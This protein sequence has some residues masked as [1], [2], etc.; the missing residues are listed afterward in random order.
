MVVSQWQQTDSDGN[1]MSLHVSTPEDG[2]IFP[3]VVVIQHQSG[4]DGFIQ[5]MTERLAGAGYVAVAPD[6]YHRD[7]PNC[8]DDMR[9]R[10]ARLG[11]RRVIVDVSAT[12]EFLKR[13]RAV[14]P[15]RIGIVGFCMGGRIVYLMAAAIPAF[16]AAVT[17]YPGNT[18]RAWGRDIPSPFERTGEIGCAL[19]GHFGDEDKNPSPE[20]RLKLDAELTKHGKVH[21]FY[22]YPHAGHAFMDDTKGSFRPDAAQAAWPR[23]LEFLGR[24]LSA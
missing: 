22:T 12:V 20:E 23:A 19:Q 17:F 4:V 6:L 2:G 1:P 5:S 18:G 16:K 11:D 13:Q 3:A 9:A 24:H 7:G 21:E 14:D 8:T 15:G 10:S